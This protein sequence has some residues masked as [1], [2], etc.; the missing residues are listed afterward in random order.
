MKNNGQIFSLD[1]LLSIVLVIVAIGLAMQ[2]LELKQIE[3]KERFDQMELERVGNTAAELLV[4]NHEIICSLVDNASTPIGTLANCLNQPTIITKIT[5]SML[6]IPNNY[7]CRIEINDT[8]VLSGDCTGDATDAKNVFAAERKIV[9]NNT[10]QAPDVS[11][12][13][14]YECMSRNL[15]ACELAYASV[16]LKAWKT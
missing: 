16:E 4:N 7:S 8:V 6:G 3:A 1:L 12:D 10:S 2:Y 11:K 14:L 15:A 13:D 9:L 5:K